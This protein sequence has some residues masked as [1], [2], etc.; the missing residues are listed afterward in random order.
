MLVG[1]DTDDTTHEA[2]DQPE[3][4][5]EDQ[6]QQN[7]AG[8]SPRDPDDK[9]DQGISA[10]HGGKQRG[11]RESHEKPTEAERSHPE[12]TQDQPDREQD[13]T[14]GNPRAPA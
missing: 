13:Q 3:A 5:P 7:E 1:P 4:E 8:N 6:D 11:Q 2:T 14:G 9:A 10:Q 12:E